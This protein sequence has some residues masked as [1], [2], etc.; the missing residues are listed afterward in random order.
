MSDA[1]IL[2][3]L[4]LI[5][6]TLTAICGG[7]GW[8]A[9]LIIKELKECAEDRIKLNIGMGGLQ[10]E[11]KDC[12]ADRI[13]LRIIIGTL[14]NDLRRVNTHLEFTDT[15]VERNRVNK[16]NDI[17]E[18]TESIKENTETIRENTEVISKEQGS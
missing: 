1:V 8:L 10:A 9:V 2:S 3:I 4:A 6:I 7:L 14:E 5:P 18:N 13:D 12:L 16:K 11:I 17:K 15:Q